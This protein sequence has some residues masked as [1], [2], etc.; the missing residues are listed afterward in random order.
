MELQA[1]SRASAVAT[2]RRRHLLPVLAAVVAAVLACAADAPAMAAGD[3]EPGRTPL[4]AYYYIWFNASSWERAKTDYPLLGRYSS[5]ERQVMRQ[6]V[7][8]AK[9]AG[10]DG[11]I[12]SWKSTSTLDARLER[13][14][15]I[16]RQERFKLAVIYQGLDFER[17]PLPS[18]QVA[19][20]LDAF[21][22]RYS[23]AAPFRLFEKPL[24]VWSGTWRFSR[25]EIARVTRPRRDRLLILG[26]ERNVAGYERLRG[27]VDGD[28]Y[29]WSSVNPDSF[30]N[31]SG[32]LRQMAA[33]AHAGGGLWIAPAAPGFDARRIGGETVVRRAD[34]ATLRREMNA[35]GQSSPDA[36]GLISWN[37]FSENTHLEPSER[38]G[39]RYLDVV[40]D[41]RGAR[42]PELEG[43]DSSE[44]GATGSGYRI[45]LLIGILALL[46]GGLA[47]IV[48]GGARG[49]RR[50]APR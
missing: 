37:E 7:R 33:A 43:F 5:D 30:P 21:E 35:A 16:A 11:F 45:Q 42:G 1:A 6:H 9:Q 34:G 19:R 15:G 48:R 41:I 2:R 26:S 4:L 10:I 44:P 23:R 24:V 40:A 27:L 29:Y 28:A 50:G 17:R 22:R 32:K 46:V 13:L 18:G 14:I 39:D 31:Y 25:R 47:L 12:V 36:I 8:W 38:H 20:D 49:R 3:R